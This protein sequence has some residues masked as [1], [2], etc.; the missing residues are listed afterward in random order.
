MRKTDDI[1]KKAYKY[2]CMGLNSK[3]I[4]KLLDISF[5][6]VQNYMTNGKWKKKRKPT[7]IKYEVAR[8]Y[9][10]GFTY[11]QIAKEI[12]ISRASVYLYLKETRT[13]KEKQAQKKGTKP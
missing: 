2:Y 11:E 7:N 12:G 13:F 3:E 6:T 10:N 9:E 1:K 5:R 4:A 8:L